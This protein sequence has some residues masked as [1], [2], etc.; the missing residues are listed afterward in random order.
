MMKPK[1][2]NKQQKE[3]LFQLVD[4]GISKKDVADQIGC[5]WQTVYNYIKR[6]GE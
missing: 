3:E 2:L 4:Q 1:E 5:H 6:R